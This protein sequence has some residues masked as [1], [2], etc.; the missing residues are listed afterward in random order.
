MIIEDDDNLV[1]G[2]AFAFER[3][4]YFVITANSLKDGLAEFMRNDVDIIIL[5]LNLPDG[6]GIGLCREIRNRSLV[7]IIMLTARDLE[8]DE[9]A[10]LTAGADDYIIKPFSLSV[11]RARVE[12]ISR[13][14]DAKINPVIQSG[15]FRLDTG[16]CK[17]YRE[18][19]E[20]PVS[21]TEFRILNY[22]MS[23]SGQILSKEQILSALWDSQG[24]YVDENTLQV[25]IS[26]LRAKIED[27]PREPRVI[28]TIHGLGYV[29][30][31]E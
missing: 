28:K 7:P 29:W 1:R 26:R 16:L 24:N 10:G 17:F 23:N 30:L 3:D 9:V 5:D 12:T 15:K 21:A 4:G 13:R 22:F 19:G 27:N 8:T 2:V 20:I 14:L 25:N 31:K 18:D 6:D 11:L